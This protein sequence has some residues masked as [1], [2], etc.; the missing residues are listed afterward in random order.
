MTVTFVGEWLTLEQAARVLG[1][2]GHPD[3]LERLR[4]LSLADEVE[5][6]ALRPGAWRVR[7]SSVR[8]LLESPSWR[9]EYPGHGR[10]VVPGDQDEEGAP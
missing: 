1:L 8:D 9:G 5:V 6:V 4:I 2:R 10:V 3:W 7:G